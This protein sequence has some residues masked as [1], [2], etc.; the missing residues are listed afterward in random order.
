[1]WLRAAFQKPKAVKLSRRAGRDFGGVLGRCV[2]PVFL[3]HR[4]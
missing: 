4:T 3:F 1:M 2:I